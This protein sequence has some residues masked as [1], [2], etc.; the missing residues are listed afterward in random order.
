M[1]L[2]E[3]AKI[4]EVS[5]STVSKALNDSPE[6]AQRT[7][8]KIIDLAALYNYQPNKVALNLKTGKT[9]TI[10]VIV[11]SIQNNFFARVIIGIEEVLNSNDYN[12][13]ISITNESQHKEIE[14]LKTLSNGVV[15]G[16]IISAAEETQINNTTKHYILAHKRNKPL[17]L[18]DR[19][20]KSLDVNKVVVD[21]NAAI[22][23]LTSELIQS[24][25]KCIALVS[26][27]FNLSVG[28]SRKKGYLRAIK[29][30]QEEKVVEYDVNSIES[31]INDLLSTNPIDAIVA[32]D[33]EASLI[34]LKVI[35]AKNIAIPEKIALIG[36]APS[37]IAN[38]VRPQL[39]TID[40][41]GVEIGKTSAQLLIDKL[42]NSSLPPKRIVV[43][44]TINHRETT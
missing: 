17:V 3:L 44:S 10:G 1:T 20:I 36:F 38:N 12:L 42:N 5:I 22:F 31:Y 24:G 16:F 21:D 7:K 34:A 23:N 43:N 27:I 32:L 11:P 39:T 28:K 6:I 40:Q 9:K 8:T 33:E 25:R 29:N 41:H 15:D 18:F 13:I 35:N 19:V 30:Q 2:K 37:N 4:A 26:T 14:M